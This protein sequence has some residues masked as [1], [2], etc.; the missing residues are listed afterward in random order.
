MS[1]N[2]SRDLSPPDVSTAP[3]AIGPALIWP[4]D[5]ME[6]VWC[7]PKTKE[8]FIKD[9]RTNLTILEYSQYN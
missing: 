7:H 9:H 1:R 4:W 6:I 5:E 8:P 2:L 3:A